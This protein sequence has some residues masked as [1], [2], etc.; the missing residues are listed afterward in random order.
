MIFVQPLF[1][2]FC[3]NFHSHTHIMFLL[4]LS[5]VLVFVPIPLFLGKIMVVLKVVYQMVV[6]ITQ[7]FLLTRLFAHQ[8]AM[9]FDWQAEL[10]SPVNKIVVNHSIAAMAPPPPKPVHNI[11]FAQALTASSTTISSNDNLPQPLIRGETVSIHIS[12]DIYKNGMAVCKR[13]LRG[14][15]VLNKGDKR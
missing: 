14:R 1:D 9:A 12:Q 8:P 10:A 4:S 11:S 5:I 13:N 7:L 3:D 15:L 6:Q 2:N